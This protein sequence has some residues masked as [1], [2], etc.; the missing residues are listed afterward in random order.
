MAIK[1]R[2]WLSLAGGLTSKERKRTFQDEGNIHRFDEDGGYYG[3]TASSSCIFKI[4]PFTICK[5]CFD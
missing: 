5:L 3:V 4:C 1:V 2:K